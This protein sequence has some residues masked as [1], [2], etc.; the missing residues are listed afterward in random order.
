MPLVSGE[1]E[2]M[3]SF[4]SS[5]KQQLYS[6]TSKTNLSAVNPSGITEPA[7]N[8]GGSLRRSYFHSVGIIRVAMLS[9]RL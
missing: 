8:S 9:L 7:V 4:V 5:K 1:M 3:T 2:Q 6:F